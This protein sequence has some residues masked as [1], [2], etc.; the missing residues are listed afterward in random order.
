MIPMMGQ[1]NTRL[2]AQ[3]SILTEYFMVDMRAE[4]T[5]A[6]TTCDSLYSSVSTLT[7]TYSMSGIMDKT[8]AIAELIP[9]PPW[10]DQS[11]FVHRHRCATPPI[12]MSQRHH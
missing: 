9:M 7:A 4:I 10:C 5:D 6:A 1:R 3:A 2:F 8:V 11:Q 12:Y